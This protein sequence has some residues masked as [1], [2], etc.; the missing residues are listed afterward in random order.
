[1]K[2]EDP[3]DAQPSPAVFA[4]D[5]VSAAVL[6]LLSGLSVGEKLPPERTLAADLG[7]S[8]PALRDR[9]RLLEALGV[10]RRRAGDGTYLQSLRPESLTLALNVAI[11]ASDLSRGALHSVRVGLERQAAREAALAA[12]PVPIAYMKRAL[13]AMA[14]AEHTAVDEADI[15]FHQA[16]MR[17]SLNSSLV[18]FG[19]AL[20]GVLRQEILGNR[21]IM[22]PL[23]DDSRLMIDLHEPIYAA[24]L[25]GDAEAAMR[26]VDGHF[27][28]FDALLR[29]LRG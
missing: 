23:A 27:E 22:H 1:M 26:A 3:G 28:G 10:L 20:H 12:E 29:R 5:A 19:E 11:Q 8:R 2:S 13:N 25:A 15:A 17:S 14:S 24:V 4:G 16:L 21:R 9:L 7:V 6:E 18:F